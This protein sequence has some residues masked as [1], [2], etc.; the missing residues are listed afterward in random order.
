MGKSAYERFIDAR[1][2]LQRLSDQRIFSAWVVT[3]DDQEIEIS[4]NEPIPLSPGQ[5]FL[6]QIQG[7]DEDAYVLANN[8]AASRF[9]VTSS[10]QLRPASQK[11]RK[12]LDAL[13][14]TLAY[15]GKD[16]DVLVA[17]GSAGGI[18]VLSWEELKKGSTVEIL[19]QL[20]PLQAR[21]T[22]EVRHCRPEPQSIGAYRIGLV[23]QNPDQST[24]EA[25]RNLLYPAA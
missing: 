17:D 11:H 21:F 1:V 14:A 13:K 20:Q 16:C 25:W 5:R 12:A 9:E 24:S 19:I 3:L 4:S 6:F 23:F 22:C 10:I 8:T 7:P 2:R 15:D 18:G